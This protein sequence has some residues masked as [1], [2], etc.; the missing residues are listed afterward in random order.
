MRFDNQLSTFEKNTLAMMQ[1]IGKARQQYEILRRGALGS[2]LQAS[3]DHLVF[4]HTG[5][6]GPAVVI[7][8]R[9]GQRSVT[10]SASALGVSDG[11]A[12][13]N[14]LAGGQITVS[15]GNLTVS[16]SGLTPVILI[17]K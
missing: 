4:L 15:G 13:E 17:K 5:Q 8:N 16:V 6:G 10:L 14:V 2:T 9:G 12:F 7:L 3:S 1:K 11:T